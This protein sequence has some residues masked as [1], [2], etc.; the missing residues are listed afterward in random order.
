MAVN[1]GNDF[2][3]NFEEKLLEAFQ[4]L[5]CF[6]F[7]DNLVKFSRNRLMTELSTSYICPHRFFDHPMSHDK[8]KPFVT[9]ARDKFARR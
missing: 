9:F 8:I 1:F 3:T 7:L 6:E 4:L 2:I 5:V